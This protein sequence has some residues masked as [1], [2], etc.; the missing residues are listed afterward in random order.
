MDFIEVTNLNGIKALILIDKITHITE[1]SSEGTV[2]FELGHPEVYVV[3][4][5][6]LD[7]VKEILSKKP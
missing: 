5:M 3:T 6:T 1:I 7:E 4:K 2:S